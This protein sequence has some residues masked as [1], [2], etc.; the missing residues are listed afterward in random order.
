MLVVAGVDDYFEHTAFAPAL[1]PGGSRSARFDLNQ[2]FR[3]VAGRHQLMRVE[4]LFRREAGA[5][6]PKAGPRHH[7]PEVRTKPQRNT[8]EHG[9]EF[10]CTTN[11]QMV[12]HLERILCAVYWERTHP[13]CRMLEIC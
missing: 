12:V 4:Q 5:R 8:E 11:R 2:K 10:I 6:N 3:V 1:L 9:S 7:Q 13:V